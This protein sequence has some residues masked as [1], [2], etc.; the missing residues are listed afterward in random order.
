MDTGAGAS[1]M[2]KVG[3]EYLLF[4]QSLGILEPHT[5]HVLARLLQSF[6]DVPTKLDAHL[7]PVGASLQA[8]ISRM[9]EADNPSEAPQHRWIRVFDRLGLFSDTDDHACRVI[10]IG[11]SYAY[12]HQELNALTAANAIMLQ[13]LRLSATPPAGALAT[14]DGSSLLPMAGPA[15]AVVPYDVCGL[16]C[17]GDETCPS[18]TDQ[19]RRV[20]AR[21]QEG[22][23]PGGNGVW[24]DGVPL[25]G[26]TQQVPPADE[27]GKPSFSG[28]L[29]GRQSGGRHAPGAGR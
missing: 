18:C 15:D 6:Y 20:R 5:L 28:R 10:N 8:A 29:I 21:G 24:G 13:D 9:C 1:M 2:P 7:D 19:R 16:C 3:D 12:R 11:L 17:T 4:F 25:P 14:K 27:D 23:G 22:A 26:A